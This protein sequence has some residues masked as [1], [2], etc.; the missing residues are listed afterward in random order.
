MASGAMESPEMHAHLPGPLVD[1]LRAVPVA[2]ANY[3]ALT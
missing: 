3:S 2:D 1:E